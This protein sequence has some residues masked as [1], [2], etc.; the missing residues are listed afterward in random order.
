MH[1]FVLYV[2]FSSCRSCSVIFGISSTVLNVLI[3]RELTILSVFSMCVFT[4]S[5]CCSFG[6]T[7]LVVFGLPRGADLM[8]YV[9]G[10]AALFGGVI[11]FG[12]LPRGAAALTISCLSV[13]G[14]PLGLLMTLSVNRI[15]LNFSSI[16]NMS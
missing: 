9:F 1:L 6:G 14:L 7:S 8:I 2:V 3:C 16:L 13:G 4:E 15:T 12:G 11:L 10:V 5:C